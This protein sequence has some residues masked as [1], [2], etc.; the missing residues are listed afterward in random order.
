MKILIADDD[1]DLTDVTEF[2]LR[3]EG[4]AVVLAR[5]GE[6][7]LASLEAE[8]PDLVLLDIGLDR[9]DGFEVCRQIRERSSIPIIMVTAR[10]SENDMGRAFGFGADDYITKPFSFRQL[11]MRIGAVAR[12][13]QVP[14]D[15]VLQ[16][17]GLRLDPAT[18]EVTMLGAP[19]RLTRLEFRL[20]HC[21][22]A[23]VQ[24][25][26][27]FERLLRFAWPTDKGDPGALK[28]HISH[29]RAKLALNR[30][31]ASMTIESVPGIGYRLRPSERERVPAGSPGT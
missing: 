27:P 20:L 16:M 21:L 6:Q 23:N 11:I 13:A 22:L 5:D 2:A 26:A 31:G 30:T 7:A 24:R 25:V 3:R 12:R 28:T 18:G 19:V 17:D 4:H 29:L 9:I 14:A 10:D 1:P 8:Q 15:A